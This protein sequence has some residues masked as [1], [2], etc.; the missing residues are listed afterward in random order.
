MLYSSFVLV[1]GDFPSI[2]FIW[3][4]TLQNRKLMFC[5][6]LSF[7][8]LSELKRGQDF[9]GIIIFPRERAWEDGA[10]EGD[11]KAQTIIGGMIP[12]PGHATQLVCTSSLWCRSSWSPIDGLDLKS[13]IKRLPKAIL[14]G[15]GGKTQ[16]HEAEAEPAKIGGWN[17]AKTIPSRFSPFSDITNTATMMKKE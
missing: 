15:G 14:R 1:Y 4:I 6:F 7:T 11:N 16:N 3:F 12:S 17:A 13:P 8:D 10:H 2:P 5:I 9:Y